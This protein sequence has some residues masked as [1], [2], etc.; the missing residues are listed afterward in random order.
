[1]ATSQTT[2]KGRLVKARTTAKTISER[3][4]WTLHDGGQPHLPCGQCA[5]AAALERRAKAE[6][7]TKRLMD[8]VVSAVSAG[9]LTPEEGG[10]ALSLVTTHWPRWHA[11][12]CAC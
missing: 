1:M 2:S 10:A 8:V 11:T 4:E 3:V 12:H 6:A 9:K 5:D 7:R